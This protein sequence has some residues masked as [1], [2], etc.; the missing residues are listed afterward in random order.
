MRAV[1]QRRVSRRAAPSRAQPRLGSAGGCATTK[2][3]PPPA[4]A[5]PRGAPGTGPG[6]RGPSGAAPSPPRPR[7]QVPGG[8]AA[9]GGGA[10]GGGCG[11]PLLPSPLLISVPHL[12]APPPRSPA[13]G[14]G[15]PRRGRAARG[16]SSPRGRPLGAGPGGGVG[17]PL[18]AG[19]APLRASPAAPRPRG[20]AALG[21]L[22][23]NRSQNFPSWKPVLVA[24]VTAPTAPGSCLRHPAPGKQGGCDPAGGRPAPRGTGERGGVRPLSFRWGFSRAYIGGVLLGLGALLHGLTWL[25][26]TPSEAWLPRLIGGSL[27]ASHSSE[28]RYH[29]EVRGL[30]EL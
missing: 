6:P 22:L 18:R 9:A 26:E 27:R 20:A 12:P 14:G 24:P 8:A 25:C 30:L 13:G 28:R 10:V 15:C 3:R 23:G 21:G 11:L 16:R 7:S 2:P 4:P 5:A 1:K 19:G 29:M 17:A